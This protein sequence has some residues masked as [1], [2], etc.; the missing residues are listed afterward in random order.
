MAVGKTRFFHRDLPGSY[1]EKFYSSEYSRTTPALKITRLNNLPA[2]NAIA[3]TITFSLVYPSITTHAKPF[4]A[5]IY[6]LYLSQTIMGY[7]HWLSII[8]SM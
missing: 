5:I 4:S 1:F 7:L 2:Y 8:N 6:K 3:H